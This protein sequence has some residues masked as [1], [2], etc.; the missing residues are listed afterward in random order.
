MGRQLHVV[1]CTPGEASHAPP[2]PPATTTMIT[3]TD[4]QDK[5]V[6]SAPQS[7]FQPQAKPASC[8]TRFPSSW[9]G[10]ST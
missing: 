6:R 2:T 5:K 8:Q 10:S 4:K 7:S 9:S 1:A 3:E